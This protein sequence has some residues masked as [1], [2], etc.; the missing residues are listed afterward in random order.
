MQ[1]FSFL[2]VKS[3]TKT[4]ITEDCFL[5]AE[6]LHILV[7]FGTMNVVLRIIHGISFKFSFTVDQKYYQAESRN[8][9]VISPV[10]NTGNE[11]CI[12]FFWNEAV[13]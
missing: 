4:K 7:F 12:L 13:H 9:P 2:S 10:V 8:P 6:S 11:F 3:K 1:C 5:G